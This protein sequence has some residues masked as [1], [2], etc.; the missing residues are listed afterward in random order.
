ME[1]PRRIRR[2]M[3]AG[4]RNVVTFVAKRITPRPNSKAYAEDLT[5]PPKIGTASRERIWGECQDLG[6]DWSGRSVHNLIFSME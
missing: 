4:V 5:C 1:T 2:S 6:F 3:S